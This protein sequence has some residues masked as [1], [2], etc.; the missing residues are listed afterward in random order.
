MEKLYSE[1]VWGLRVERPTVLPQKEIQRN[2]KVSGKH[3]APAGPIAAQ[4]EPVK[5]HCVTMS[6]V[7]I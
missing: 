3:G 1:I 5:P 2:S 4:W 7:A 6:L